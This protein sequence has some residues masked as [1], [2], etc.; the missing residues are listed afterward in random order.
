MGDVTTVSV[1]IPT[2]N[3]PEFLKRAVRSALD[4]TCS[5]L[6]VLVCDDGSTDNTEATV[7]SF[8]DRRVI[9]LPGE[10]AGGPAA[11]RNRG[12]KAS[13]GEWI[14]FLDDDDVW[15][16]EKLEQQ[17]RE[18]ADHRIGAV[19]C[20]AW[21]DRPGVDGATPLLGGVNATLRFKN[22][23]AANRVICSSMMVQRDILQAAG[24]FPEDAG[25]TA[26][27]DYALWLRVA[28][29]T[30]IAY[31][32]VPL[33][34]YR[35]DS[36]H[37]IRCNGVEIAEQRSRILMDYLGWKRQKVA[38]SLNLCRAYWYLFTEVF[39]QRTV[40]AQGNTE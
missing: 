36:E 9:W 20:D 7:R 32:A 4:Q 10:R 39:G 30:S 6:E 28:D 18:I 1:V 3:R 22:M 33:L 25:L 27:E 2:W 29:M 38:V 14:A 23:L 26:M 13:R 37:S 34:S 12:I 40:A 35:D 19:C 15:L 24:G 5:P 21:R 16:P 8:D 17:L 31:C 11:A